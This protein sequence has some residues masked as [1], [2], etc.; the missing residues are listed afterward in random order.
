MKNKKVISF[1]NLPTRLPLNSTVLYAFLLHYFNCGGFAWGAFISVMSFVWIGTIY[2]M[3][4]ENSINIFEEP[5]AKLSTF[6]SKLDEI[7]ERNKKK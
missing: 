4:S 6:K 1:K 3:V 5:K 7:I 2:N